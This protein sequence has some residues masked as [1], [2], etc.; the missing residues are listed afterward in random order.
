MGGLKSG[1][2]TFL[3]AWVL[4]SGAARAETAALL[5]AAAGLSEAPPADVSA[6]DADGD[7]ALTIVDAVI[8][9]RS[10][11]ARNGGAVTRTTANRYGAD[12]VYYGVMIDD[13]L[14]N[15]RADARI[16]VTHR[17]VNVSN[18]VVGVWYYA[19]LGRWVIFNEDR[20]PMRNGE[21]FHYAFGD[22]VR[23][24][25]ASGTFRTFLDG[26]AA[27]TL[28]L[29]THAYVA[30]YNPSPVGVG[31]ANPPR[32]YAYNEDYT[33]QPEGELLFVADAAANGGVAF[34]AASNDYNGVGVYLDDPRLEGNP[35]AILLAG[36][37][38]LRTANPSPIGVWYE[39][40]SGRWLAY[41]ETGE[42]LPM[43][44]AI[45]YFIAAP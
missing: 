14:L 13:P 41:N 27:T 8:S 1:L 5:R 15:G 28:P 33:D 20:S 42:A 39:E 7:G 4:A 31:F 26:F 16:V 17:F 35:A 36:H 40:V 45:H 3:V 23:A 11:G 9:A 6:G 10:A 29:A 19:A 2:V 30:S 24:L 38:Y 22:G 18:A 44:E 32:W 21:V 43:G 34:H 37:A 12:G 25:P